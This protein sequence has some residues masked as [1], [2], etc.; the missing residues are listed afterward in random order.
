MSHPPSTTFILP[1]YNGAEFVAESIES[2]C[3]QTFQDWTLLILDNCSSDN[4]QE[5]CAPF[6]KDARI[7]YIRNEKNIGL[8]GNLLKGIELTQTPYWC[9]VCH[10]DKFTSPDAVQIAYDILEKDP[11]ISMVTSPCQWMDSKSRIF[12]SALEPVNGKLDGDEVAK[13]MMRRTRITFGLIMLARTELVKPF[14]PEVRWQSVADAD[15]FI[16]I[17]KGRKVFIYE[18]PMYA[19]RFHKSNN[20]MSTYIDVRAKYRL[21]AQKHNIQLSPI[22]N[23]IQF[24]N[25]I[26]VVVA[27]TLFFIYL[28][29][30][31]K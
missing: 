23:V 6:L 9:Y 20:S 19:V 16:T 21:V 30:F 22:E 18:Q 13:V 17:S 24:F 29:Y 3:S 27:K 31:R 12:F 15:L 25:N 4:T 7:R 14:L 5:V 26:K 1:V 28:N 11:E 2:I 8:L 10:D